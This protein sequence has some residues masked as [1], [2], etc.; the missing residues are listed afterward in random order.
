MFQIFFGRPSGAGNVPSGN[1][2]SR[3]RASTVGS[4]VPERTIA[5]DSPPVL[6]WEGI[7]GQRLFNRYL[8]ELGLWSRKLAQLLRFSLREYL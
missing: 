2:M 6:P 5:P 7:V 8:H 1:D 3:R 4:R